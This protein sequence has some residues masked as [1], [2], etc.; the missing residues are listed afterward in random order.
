MTDGPTEHHIRV[1][2]A[3]AVIGVGA[4]E[5]VLTAAFREGYRW[6]SVCGGEAMCGTC[7]VKV[8]EGAEHTSQVKDAEEFR[9]KFIGRGGDPSIRLACQMRISG[10]V[11]VFK[12]GVR[13]LAPES[14][15]ESESA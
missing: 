5:P 11:T 6:P 8:T 12:R 9:L 2:P 1:E 10:D 3:G 14:E 15:S 4:D 7:F 13:K